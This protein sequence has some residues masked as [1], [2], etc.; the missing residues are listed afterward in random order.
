MKI[1]KKVFDNKKKQ[2]PPEKKNLIKIIERQRADGIPLQEIIISL[3]II[4]KQAIKQA[5]QTQT[6]LKPSSPNFYQVNAIFSA[7]LDWAK[8]INEQQEELQHIMVNR[9]NRG[10]QLEQKGNI[11]KA[12]QLYETNIQDRFNG[13]H[14]YNRLRIIYTKQQHYQDAIRVCR[15]YLAL[16]NRET[17][18]DKAH[19]KHH[20]QKL[21]AK[22]KVSHR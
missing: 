3:D 18:Q 8:F 16:P 5:K 13:T 20:L 22:E 14:P 4:H 17:G 1:L 7:Q 12:I 19:F 21:Q 9:N 2:Y 6:Q 11:G 10:R 15:A